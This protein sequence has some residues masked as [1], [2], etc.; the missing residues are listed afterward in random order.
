[1]QNCATATMLIEMPLT[2]AAEA[3]FPKAPDTALTAFNVNN[4]INQ[5]LTEALRENVR[6]GGA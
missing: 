6:A 2:A 3:V 4:C 1:M 5:L